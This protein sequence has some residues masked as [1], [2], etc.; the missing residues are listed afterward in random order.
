MCLLKS[1][2]KSRSELV[3]TSA[4]RVPSSQEYEKD[5]AEKTG[6]D[7]PIESKVKKKLAREG[8]SRQSGFPKENKDCFETEGVSNDAK[9]C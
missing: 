2:G 1:E 6:N 8:K 5:V 3:G 7:Q 4:L 9:R